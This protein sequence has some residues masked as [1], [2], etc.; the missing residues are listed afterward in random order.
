MMMRAPDDPAT[1]IQQV[2][3][4]LQNFKY[5]V[6]GCEN[7]YSNPATETSKLESKC[8][9]SAVALFL[10]AVEPGAF[11]L[12]NGWDEHFGSPLGM[13]KGPA[14]KDAATGTWSRGFAGGAATTWLNGTGMVRWGGGVGK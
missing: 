3:T 2:T 4:G 10:L 13:P 1:M 12:C 8:S 11:L 7:C 6:V 5:V 9:E 14:K